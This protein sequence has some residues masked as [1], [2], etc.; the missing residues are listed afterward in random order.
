MAKINYTRVVGVESE[1]K[2]TV[3]LTVNY[4]VKA[5]TEQL[6]RDKAMTN[7]PSEFELIDD[8]VKEA[9]GDEED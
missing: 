9:G 4:H 5:E 1:K 6:A 7:L 3:T 2:F 8:E